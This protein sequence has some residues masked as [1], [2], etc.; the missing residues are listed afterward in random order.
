MYI[1]AFSNLRT[2]IR[3]STLFESTDHKT[4]LRKARS[5][6][7]IKLIVD[8]RRDSAELGHLVEQNQRIL[9]ISRWRFLWRTELR[10]SALEKEPGNSRSTIYQV[11]RVSIVPKSDT[12]ELELPFP[13]VASLFNNHAAD[14]DDRA[15]ALCRQVTPLRRD[16]LINY[17]KPWCP[18]IQFW[19]RGA[20]NGM[21]RRT[22]T[23]CAEADISA[24]HR[25]IS[26]KQSGGCI[27]S[28]TI[29]ARPIVDTPCV[30]C[31]ATYQLQTC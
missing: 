25:Y 17:A 27:P 13:L 5:F 12:R 23:V 3:H 22:V 8:D 26:A 20:Y 14:R 2:W 1:V 28:L 29:R 9:E 11:S 10:I 15:S 19:T 24:A 31:P 30:D 7:R 6:L 18:K 21:V 16:F 4:D